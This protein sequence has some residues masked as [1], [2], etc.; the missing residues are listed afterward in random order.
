MSDEPTLIPGMENP[1]PGDRDESRRSSRRWWW[2]IAVVVLLGVVGLVVW[3]TAGDDAPES[4][5]SDSHDSRFLT[6][7]EL[8]ARGNHCALEAATNDPHMD[9]EIFYDARNALLEQKGDTTLPPHTF[10]SVGSDDD[11]REMECRMV[12]DTATYDCRS[13]D[14]LQILLHGLLGSGVSGNRIN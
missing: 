4:L 5:F 14:G 8:A 9:C 2:L 13:E 10:I 3:L 12:E 11:E 7:E 1:A 6:P